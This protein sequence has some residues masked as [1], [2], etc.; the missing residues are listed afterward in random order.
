M[1]GPELFSISILKDSRLEGVG[2][3]RSFNVQVVHSSGDGEIAETCP[4]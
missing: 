4:P 2:M 3:P 1:V